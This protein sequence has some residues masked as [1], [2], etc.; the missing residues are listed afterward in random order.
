MHEEWSG[1]IGTDSQSVLDTLSTGDPDIQD[2][3]IPVDLNEG[4]VV[5][6]ALCPE[7]D[8]L[9]EI[10]E[11]MKT[12]P[13]VK[14]VYV[15][16]HQDRDCAYEQIDL[17]GQLNVDAD[18]VAGEF[19]DDHGADRPLVLMLPHT[20]AHLILSDGTIT[21][22]YDK[23]LQHKATAK[24]LLDYIR[25]KNSWSQSVMD[26]IH[27]EVHGT[28]IKKQSL[29]KTHMVKLLHELLPTTGQANKFDNG[30]RQCPL[31]S[32]QKEDRDHIL[33]CPHPTQ[34]VWRDTFIQELTD[35]CTQKETD[36]NLQILLI[37]SIQGWFHTPQ[38]YSVGTDCYNS[39][40]HRLIHQQNRIGWR[41]IF[42]GRFSREWVRIQDSHYRRTRSQEHLQG[43]HYTGEKWLM[44][45]ILFV[46][47]K[48]YTLWKQRTQELHG[49]DQR[50]RAEAERSDV[51]RQLH[52]IYEKRHQLEPRVQE[53]LFARIEEHY[54]VPP[55]VTRNWL[56]IHTSLLQDSMRR[57]K[58]KAIQ[59]VRSIRTY[60]APAR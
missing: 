9:I 31:C 43:K 41:Q 16:G 57:V 50:T 24:P 53:L 20:K 17:M 60:F 46:W 10:Q 6:D 54:K 4:A 42:H 51:R 30:K 39:V 58:A 52:A 49:C 35:H 56:A 55:A 28:A 48:W 5:L 27:W 40:L 2:E 23:Y 3:D 33:C 19:Q 38:D 59:G 47:D 45:L 29:P 44:G 32:S 18:Q 1:I 22:N 13:R 26:S 14:L 12:L 15:K 37:H 25:R 36:P 34:Q 21:G 7:W 11:A 8:V